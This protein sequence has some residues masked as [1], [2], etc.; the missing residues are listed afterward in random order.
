MATS[1]RAF[2]AGLAA[3]PCP[4]AALGAE[5][6]SR[7]LA[8]P[9]L[10]L[11]VSGHFAGVSGGALIVA[12]G[13]YFPK[14]LFE[15]GKKV[16]TDQA[17]VLERGADKWLTGYHL[18]QRLAYGAS[19]STGDGLICIGGG[20][21][22][23]HTDSVFRLRW[24]GR[25][26]EREELPPLPG[27]CAFHAAAILDD[28]LYV[29]GGQE[30]P[31]SLARHTLWVRNLARPNASWGHQEP[32]PGPARILPAMAVQGGSVFLMGGCTLHAGADG[33]P[34]REYLRDA[35]RLT[36]GSGWKRLADAPRAMTAA[37]ATPLGATRV[38]I[39]GGDDG[40]NAHRVQELKERHPGFCKDVLSLDTRT[41]AWSRAETMPTG[42][43][44]T[45]IVRWGERLVIPGGEDRPGHRSTQVLARRE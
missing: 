22:V 3:L 27:R 8:L 6:T 36:P 40:E 9:P 16:W 42:L 10:P 20:D 14:S 1:R 12:G 18:E 7:W 28:M 4:T 2:L 37:P 32:W 21:A 34:A 13:A 29:A 24:R 30:A 15:G 41:G 38:L 5:R 17:A 45:N 35:Y 43:V 39:F 11:A 19:V 33:K 26:L 23:G 44:T 25:R 31:D